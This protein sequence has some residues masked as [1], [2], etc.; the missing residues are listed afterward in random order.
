MIRYLIGFFVTVGLVILLVILLFTGGSNTANKKVPATGKALSSYASSDA[1]VRL[2]IDGPVN[3]NQDH[4]Q[5]QYIIDRD[6]AVINLIQGYD[7]MVIDTHSY[8][9][10]EASYDTFLHALELNGFTRGKTS[11]A[12]LKSETGHCADGYRYVFELV[13]GGRVI[14]RLWTTSCGSVRTFEGNS[15]FIIDLFRSQIPGREDL[16]IPSGL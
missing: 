5:T 16:A 14:E 13:Q 7:G 11:D 4:R 9:N 15:Q 3:A 6:N 10:T 1:Q 12:S 8:G 2:T